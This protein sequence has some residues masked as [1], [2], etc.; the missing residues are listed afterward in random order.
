M[1]NDKLGVFLLVSLDPVGIVPR[2][3]HKLFDGD[4][5]VSCLVRLH[6]IDE[7]A[8]STNCREVVA[9]VCATVLEDIADDRNIE[10]LGH[11]QEDWN[12]F[13]EDFHVLDR[14]YLTV[15]ILVPVVTF[16]NLV[17]TC[18]YFFVDFH[19]GIGE[20]VKQLLNMLC[21]QCRLLISSQLH[22]VLDIPEDFRSGW[23]KLAEVCATNFIS[24]AI[25]TS[26]KDRKLLCIVAVFAFEC[27]GLECYLIYIVLA[28]DFVIY[29]VTIVRDDGGYYRVVFVFRWI[30]LNHCITHTKD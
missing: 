19:T 21:V 27:D 5:E 23:D 14:H 20:E 29:N 7:S 1:V 15:L 10:S 12:Y 30:T 28:G 6:K 3:I 13:L 22:N 2:I 8:D 9:V 26:H 16:A 25:H 4:V 24:I 11:R 17:H 18:H